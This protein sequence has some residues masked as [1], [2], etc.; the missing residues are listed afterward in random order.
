MRLLRRR[1]RVGRKR[2]RISMRVPSS[3]RS[4]SNPDVCALVGDGAIPH[5]LVF[6]TGMRFFRRMCELL[7]GSRTSPELCAIESA[8]SMRRD[9]RIRPLHSLV[10]TWRY[11]Y[12]RRSKRIYA[13]YGDKPSFVVSHVKVL[14][15]NSES[16]EISLYVGTAA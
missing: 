10:E 15:W 16:V 13:V 14:K 1:L 6:R 5:V 8:F 4:V 2:L 9:K 11:W 3:R 12:R 7:K